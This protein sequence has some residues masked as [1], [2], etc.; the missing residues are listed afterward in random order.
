MS[1]PRTVLFICV[2]NAGRSLMA[3]AIF[4]ANPADGWVAVSAGTAPALVPNPR[5][6]PM[7]QEIGLELPGHLPRL[8]TPE[9]ID[10]A[11]LRIT[12]GCLDSES[13]P[14]RLKSVEVVDWALPDP[15]KLDDAGFRG[16]RDELR[17]RIESLKPDLAHRRSLLAKSGTAPSTP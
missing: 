1:K 7:L 6:G 8:L 2:Q 14:A 5:T 9:I 10:G 13:C 12:M 17:S 11:D 4:N 3:E 16:V 15:G